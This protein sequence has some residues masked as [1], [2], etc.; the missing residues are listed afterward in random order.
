MGVYPGSWICNRTEICQL[1]LK[2]SALTSPIGVMDIVV[3]LM[4]I[5]IGKRIKYY[6]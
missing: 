5:A 4:K 3:T 6:L 1:G 2:S